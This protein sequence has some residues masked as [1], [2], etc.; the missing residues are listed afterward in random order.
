MNGTK[1]Q[2]LRI[3]A[4]YIGL[5]FRAEPTMNSPQFDPPSGTKGG[6]STLAVVTLVAGILSWTLFPMLAA[7]VGCITGWIELGNI[8]KGV[9]SVDGKLITQIGL[10]ACVANLALSCLGV[11]IGIG[12]Y[13]GLFALVLGGAALSEI[14]GAGAPN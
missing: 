4:R 9:S 8:K 5:Q 2:L 14:N 7:M 1:Y 3:I 13:F 6:A 11:C 12:A 10:A